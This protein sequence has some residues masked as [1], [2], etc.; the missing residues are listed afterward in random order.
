MR[1]MAPTAARRRGGDGVAVLRQG[2]AKLARR[3]RGVGEG[4]DCT[5]D[6]VL[7]TSPC[8]SIYRRRG[9]GAG[10]SRWDLEGGRRPRGRGLAPQARGAPPFRVPPNPRRMGPRGN[11]AQP[12]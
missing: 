11:G 5:L 1:K 8:P 12:T 7:Q 3:R 6:V 2:F 4:R 10:P 9:K